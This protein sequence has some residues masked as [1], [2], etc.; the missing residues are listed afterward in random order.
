MRFKKLLVIMSLLTFN[1]LLD[2]KTNTAQKAKVPV[3]NLSKPDNNSKNLNKK[4]ITNVK[5]PIKP[6]IRTSHKEIN[7]KNEF[8]EIVNNSKGIKIVKFYA[9]W[10][11]ACNM[12]KDTFVKLSNKYKN[13]VN[14][15]AV[16]IDKGDLKDMLTTYKITSVPT[17]IVF[18]DGKEV[19]K[20]RGAMGESELDSKI[21]KIID[22]KEK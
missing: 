18:K 4:N 6:A 19:S 16:D 9:D 17:V 14:F 21:K 22:Q 1:T 10:C 11:G 2:S 12:F 13:D 7:N 3:K 15:L 20:E 5:K 8:E